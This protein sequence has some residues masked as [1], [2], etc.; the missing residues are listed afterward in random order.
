MGSRRGA[1]DD[2]WRGMVATENEIAKSDE[3]KCVIK[4]FKE[5]NDLLLT[6]IL[7]YN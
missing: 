4:T 3:G 5:L 7:Y 6:I 1:R 2:L